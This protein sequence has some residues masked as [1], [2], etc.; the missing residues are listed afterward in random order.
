MISRKTPLARESAKHRAQREASGLPFG[1]KRSKPI[2]KIGKSKAKRQARNQAYY[3][4]AEWRAKRK[5]VFARDGYRCTE[6]IP[7]DIA[8]ANCGALILPS[9]IFDTRRES[10]GRY[11]TRCLAHGEIVNGQQTAKGLVC[12]ETSYGHRGI[13]GR[14]DTC[15]TRCRDCDRRQTPLE[16][17]NWANGARGRGRSGASA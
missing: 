1:P 2:A 12:E 4:S 7:Y 16:R 13:P 10:N 9:G 14:I 11:T 17:A 15:R 3:H 5:A 8:A 6:R